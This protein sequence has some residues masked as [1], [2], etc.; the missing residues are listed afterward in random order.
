MKGPPVPKPRFHPIEAYGF[1][2]V[3]LG[4]GRQAARARDHVPLRADAARRH[5]R[6]RTV[7]PTS[8]SGPAAGPSA[9]RSSFAS[10]IPAT[11]TTSLTLLVSP[12]TGKVT[13][14][15]GVRELVLP[16]RRQL[17]LRPEGHDVLSHAKAPR[18]LPARG[19]DG[20]GAV[21][22]RRHDDPVGAGRPRRGQPHGSNMSQAIE[23]GRCKMSE[24][25]EKQLKLGF[26]E[27]EEKD[28]SPYCCD[29]KE[30]TGF[31]C[32][33]TV[34]RVLLPQPPAARRRGRAQLGPGRW[35]GARRGRHRSG[36]D[37]HCRQPARQHGDQPAGWRDARPRRRPQEHRYVAAVVLRRRGGLGLAHAGLQPRLPVAEA[38]PRDRDPQGHGHRELEGGR[39]QAGLRPHAVHHQPV[40]GGSPGQPHARQGPWATAG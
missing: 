15:G 17:R 38:A 31:N 5:R 19:P 25:E 27:I 33:W 30:V 37:V 32:D 14:K 1:G 4:Q 35:A 34:E 36:L 2:D 39:E 13:V 10:A 24:L 9:R 12:L 26:P 7:G 16:D 3:E 6:A 11:R 8:T 28:T 18:F 29:D 20:G 21:R 22:R 40:A 23:L